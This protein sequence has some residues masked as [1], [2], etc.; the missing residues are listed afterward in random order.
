M[1]CYQSVLTVGTLWAQL[2]LQFST[3][4][5]ETLQM[6]LHGMKICMWFGYNAFVIFLLFLLCEHNL[7]FWH[8]MLSV[9]TLWARLLLQFSTDYFET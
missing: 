3:N 2:L 8:E 5:F 1:K 6:F 4:C 9:D 7:Y